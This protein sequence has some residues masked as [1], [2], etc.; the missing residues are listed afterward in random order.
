MAE[1]AR[2]LLMHASLHALITSAAASTCQLPAI[3]RILLQTGTENS[4]KFQEAVAGALAH[5]LR[6]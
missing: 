1:D 2:E 3:G 4:G 6:V 5:E